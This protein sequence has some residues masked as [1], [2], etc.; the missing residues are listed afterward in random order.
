MIFRS[1]SNGEWQSIRKLTSSLGFE[2]STKRETQEPCICGARE[3]ALL[4]LQ[5][6]HDIVKNGAHARASLHHRFV[7][8][9]HQDLTNPQHALERAHSLGG[10]NITPKSPHSP[11]PSEVAS[12][13]PACCAALGT[14]ATAIPL[15]H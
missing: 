10:A 15:L 9:S 12:W 2:Q 7:V 4:T 11:P 1:S 14:R 3:L 8:G 13:R 6:H 5:L